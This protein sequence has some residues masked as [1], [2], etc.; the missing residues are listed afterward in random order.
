MNTKKTKV[1]YT[2]IDRKKLSG[3]EHYKYECVIKNH[4]DTAAEIHFEPYVWGIWEMVKSSHEYTKSSSNQIEYTIIVPA[5]S[6]TK[7]EFEYRIDRRTEVV[8]KK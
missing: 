2:E 7:V 3:F 5:D 6:E 4:K 1:D 8:I